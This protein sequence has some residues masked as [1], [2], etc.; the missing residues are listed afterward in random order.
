MIGQDQW[1]QLLLLATVLVGEEIN[2]YGGLKTGFGGLFEILSF[3]D[4]GFN[5]LDDVLY[6]FWSVPDHD[7][8][9]N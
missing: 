4:S 6:C 1:Q 5:K 3:D 9:G 7:K 2:N 8:N